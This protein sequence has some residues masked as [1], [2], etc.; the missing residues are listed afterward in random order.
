M[1]G[2]LLGSGIVSFVVLTAAAVVSAGNLQTGMASAEVTQSLSDD[3][4]L[5]IGGYG[6]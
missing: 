2:A 3:R 5:W 4:P 6:R 1:P